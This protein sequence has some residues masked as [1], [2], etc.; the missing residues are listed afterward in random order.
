MDNNKVNS[1]IEDS[2]KLADSLS[3]KYNYPS[4]ITHLLY[5]IIPAFVIKYGLEN[6][7]V[8]LEN[9]KKIPVLIDDKNDQIY[10]A[11]YFCIPTYE[12]NNYNTH[13]GIVLK[14]YHNISLMELLDNLVHEFNH[15]MNSINQ[16]LKF[17]EDK[18]YIRSGLTF[19]IYEKNSLTPIIKENTFILEEI[20]NT[21]QTEMIIDII[22]SFN[23]YEI[24][25]T[26][27]ITTLY[28]IKNSILTKYQSNAYLM[29]SLVCK[30]L[31]ENKTFLSTIENLRFKGNINEI[32]DWFDSI[33]GKKNSYNRLIE[34]LK[35]TVD[36][37][38]Q[39]TKTKFK[40]FTIRKLRKL[41]KEAI[42]I[43]NLFD[44]NCNYT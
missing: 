5:L 28:S 8:I 44:Q 7:R 34:L 42:M 6:K 40:Y 24:D 16:E 41:N 10:Q 39:L 21:K 32:E 20:I 17:S 13:K 30:K 31:I 3:R 9:F 25:N 22:N 1:I 29:Q 18:L 12:N 36:Y 38:L 11:Y 23:N 33:T 35:L 2:I 43:V 4:N 27:V 37:Q 26:T 14:N 15:A 19:I